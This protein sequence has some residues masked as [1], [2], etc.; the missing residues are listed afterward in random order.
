M[1][2]DTQLDIWR[3][4]KRTGI[5]ARYADKGVTNFDEK[6]LGWEVMQ[7]FPLFYRKKIEAKV[8]SAAGDD[9]DPLEL[10]LTVQN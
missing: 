9:L 1:S 2:A 3:R 4:Q 6:S 7:V 10:L 5:S 8:S